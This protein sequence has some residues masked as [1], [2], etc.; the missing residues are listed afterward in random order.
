MRALAGAAL[1]LLAQRA[2]AFDVSGVGLG[3][4]ESAIRGT[5]PSAYCKPLE[6]TSRAAERRCDDAKITFAGAEARVTFFLRED[7]V[8]GFNVRFAASERQRVA[9]ALRSRWGAPAAETHDVIKREG[10]SDR[11]VHRTTW[12]DGRDRATL[13]WRPDHKR[14]WL[15][16][17]RGDFGEEIYRVR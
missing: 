5:F 7:A 6:W 16:V 11:E 3:G 17:S 9:D 12:V 2:L 13:L 8:Q 14:V 4:T 1:L 10:Q 15:M